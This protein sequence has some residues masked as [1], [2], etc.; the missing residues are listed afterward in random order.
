MIKSFVLRQPI[1]V[2]ALIVIAVVAALRI[3]A[4]IGFIP[5]DW[6]LTEEQVQLWLERV[7]MVWAAW[8]AWRAV[9]PVKEPRDERG[10]AL[11]PASTR[12]SM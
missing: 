9:T 10:Q 12:R 6:V 7:A 4:L 8:S 2:R 1:V 3:G 11:V 5:P